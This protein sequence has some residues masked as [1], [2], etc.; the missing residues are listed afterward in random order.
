MRCLLFALLCTPWWLIPAQ[1][2]AQSRY[3]DYLRRLD[4]NRNGRLE[5]SEMS[6]RTRSFLKRY[7]EASGLSLSES[8]SIDRWDRAFRQYNDRRRGRDSDYRRGGSDRSDGEAS[9]VPGFGP[10]ENTP[11]IPGFG[12]D[13]EIR[14]AFLPE[15]LQRAESRFE[16]DDRNGDGAIDREE[17]RRA[18]WSER[19]PF[20][21]DYNNDQRLTINEIAQRYARR[22]VQQAREDAERDAR[23]AA[24]RAQRSDDDNDERRRDDDGDRRSRDDDRDDRRRDGDGDGPG[25]GEYYLASNVLERHD[26]N[27][28]RYLD[29]AEWP[30]LGTNAAEADS[31]RDGRIS[32]DELA[33]WLFE[34]TKTSVREL[35]PELPDWFF[36][37]D[38]NQDGQVSMAEFADEW[39]DDK[40]EEFMRYDR[41]E[42][43]ILREDEL[44]QNDFAVGGT[45]A[46]NEARVI[47]PRSTLVAEID[48]EDDYLIGDLDVQLS[49]THT[50]AEHIDAYLIGP[51]GQRVEL[52]TGVGRNDDHF[53]GTILDDEATDSITAARPPFQG[54]FRP[55]SAGREGPSLSHF[56]GHSVHGLWQLLIRTSRSDRSGVLHGWSLK[57]KPRELAQPPLQPSRR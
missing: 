10:D 29:R 53:D 25:R 39:S 49:I 33:A 13:A 12:A 22:R 50:Y 7:A 38:L 23:R 5:P 11:V 52:F 4:D 34:E 6:E 20:I 37:R 47:L 45:F 21:Y 42:D 55:E 44:L 32:R 2:W 18:R 17:A 24:E 48:V 56:Y 51:D 3:T 28:N 31:N 57:V 43:G 30:R 19:D 16:R 14:Y 27:R 26:L 1:V 54:R 40:A 41:D 46:D 35:P 8:V 36:E 9:L 15:D